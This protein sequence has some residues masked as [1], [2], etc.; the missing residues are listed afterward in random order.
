MEDFPTLYEA[1][2]SMYQEDIPFWLS[3]AAWVGEPVLELG[4]GSG[5]VLLP[6]Q[7]AGRL[8]FGFDRNRGMLK[9]LQR[10]QPALVFC[11][12]MAAIPLRL[13]FRLIILPCNT[14]STLMED[15]R[16]TLLMQVTHLL[17]P[18]G[19]F[20][21]S[22]PNP[23]LM[24]AI[25]PTA[26]TEVE[27]FITHPFDGLPVQISNSWQRTGAQ[28][29]IIWHYDHLY[30]DGTVNRLTVEQVHSL[31]TPHEYEEEFKQ[32]GLEIKAKYGNFDRSQF[33]R[34]S[35]YLIYLLQNQ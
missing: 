22:L 11:A 7:Q 14:Y 17:H 8:V 29:K 16:M 30:P 31:Q 20:A 27:E 35:P 2:H 12:D 21:I 25:P 23:W 26:D 5:R 4:C 13:L 15:E 24:R 9:Q 33:R 1:H 18:E 34:T 10:K 6:I 32:A 19:I 28:L 3:L